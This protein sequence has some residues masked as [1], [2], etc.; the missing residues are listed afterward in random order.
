M[1]AEAMTLFTNL[2]STATYGLMGI[3]ALKVAEHSLGFIGGVWKHFIRPRKWLKS[4]YARSGVTPWVVI[5]G[6]MRL[7][8]TI[9]ERC[10]ER[11]SR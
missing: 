1:L 4:R 6:M 11:R 10:S 3:G 9:V 7:F 8:H 5:S 2:P